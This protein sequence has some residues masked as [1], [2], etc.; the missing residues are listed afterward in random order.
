M[1]QAGNIHL[2]CGA[3]ADKVGLHDKALSLEPRQRLTDWRL[4]N[5]EFPNQTIDRYPASGGKARAKI[6]T[7]KDACEDYAKTHPGEAE[8][9]RRIVYSDPIARVR[10]DKLRKHHL[11]AWRSRV[12]AL[13]ALVS[14]RKERE[15][16]TR[17][18]APSTV[19]RDLVPLRAALSKHL[20]PGAPNS[21]SA[22]Q[23]SLRPIKNADRQRTLYLDIGERRKLLEKIDAEA[24]PFVKA[25]AMLPLRPGAMANLN[26]GD[27]DKRTRELTIGKDKTGKPR[28]IALPL[29]A[30][31]FLAEQ[32][33][34][35]LPAAPMFMRGNGKRWTKDDWNDPIQAAAIGAGLNPAVTA[36]VFR[37]SVL[38]DLVDGG[39]P[40][41]TVAQLSDTSVEMI[42]RH[43]GHLN[44]SA[45]EQALAALAL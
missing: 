7:V 14:R 43:Y 44:K 36:Y 22:W 15:K 27:F 41:L 19:N 13:P 20:A 25:I 5:S 26:A 31:D 39:L 30:A 32:T 12:E 42:E 23:E 29:A 11:E 10:L 16:V 40:I 6:E 2:A 45:A 9:L 21:P 24:L 4:R 8:R 34:D 38:T 28:R 37:H 35:K 3:I 1:P 17:E 33:K 18:R